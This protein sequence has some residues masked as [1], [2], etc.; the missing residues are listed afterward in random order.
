M[1]TYR[2]NAMK[3]KTSIMYERMRDVL[4][5][6]SE[7]NPLLVNDIYKGSHASISGPKLKGSSAAIGLN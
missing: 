3:Q 4:G 6:V 5:I 1:I 7:K 2:I